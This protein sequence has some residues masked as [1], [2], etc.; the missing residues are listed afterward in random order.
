V[1]DI[2]K[3]RRLQPVYAVEKAAQ[4]VFQA[5]LGATRGGTCHQ[6]H[7]YDARLFLATHRKRAYTTD[8]IEFD[9][10]LA[11]EEV[12]QEAQVRYESSPS[13]VVIHLHKECGDPPS[14][15]GAKKRIPVRNLCGPMVK[16]RPWRSHRLN[17]TVESEKLWARQRGDSCFSVDPS[18]QLV[19][20][21]EL[22]ELH[23]NSLTEMT[24][25]I[26]A[27]MLGHA[28]LHLHGTRW[29]YPSWGASYII[30]YK[31]STAIPIR[32]YIHV[33]LLEDLGNCAKPSTFDVDRD[34]NLSEDE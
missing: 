18:V 16:M 23:P 24:K 19:T 10:F 33:T 9:M 14:K 1:D 22:I 17:L 27:V 31:V 21:E 8:N 4:S 13:A 12:W 26:V 3:R 32:P 5:L 29:I 20:L 25:R 7:Q 28:V 30:F 2:T 15:K 34:E 11:F 6:T